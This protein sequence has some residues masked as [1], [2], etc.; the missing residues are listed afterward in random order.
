MV[1]IDRLRGFVLERCTEVSV[2]T[3]GDVLLFR[4][5]RFPSHAAILVDTDLVIHAFRGR[6]VIQEAV[7]RA[8][9]SPRDWSVRGRRGGAA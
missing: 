3:P 8:R 2:P 6:G 1:R 4:Y 5:G 9:R 7:P